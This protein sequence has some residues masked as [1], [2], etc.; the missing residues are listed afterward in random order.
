[1]SVEA[2]EI[3][4]PA[5]RWAPPFESTYGPAVA[6]LAAMAGLV[7]DPEQRLA[8]D[9]MFAEDADGKWSSFEFAIVCARQNMKTAVLQAAVLGDLFLLED[10]LVIWTA[11]LFDTA[12]EAFRDIDNL[13]SASHEMSRR[14]LKVN[15]AN[16]DEGFE[17]KTGARLKFKARSKTA[18]RGL[19]GDKV[20][21]DEAFA[22]SAGEMGALLPTM[23][24]RPNPQLRYA[25]SAG[26]ESSQFLRG[27]RDR[28]R[29]GGDPSLAYLEWC[30]PEGSCADERCVH[31]L[32]TPGCALDDPEMWRWANPAMDRRISRE[33]IAS[34]RRALATEP[35]EFARERLGW[36][37]DPG[38]AEM[39]YPVR[40]W[41]A[42]VDSES[43]PTYAAPVFAI[44]TNPIRTKSAIAVC[45]ANTDGVQ[46]VQLVDFESG[47]AWVPARVK[48]LQ[49]KYDA[50][51]VMAADS[52]ASSLLPELEKLG[53]RVTTANGRELT[54]ACGSMFDALRDRSF[55]HLGQ[56]DLDDAV[57]MARK[58]E[59][60]GAWAL[61]RKGGDI[62]PLVAAVLARHYH[63]AQ[64][65]PQPTVAFL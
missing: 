35:E 37:S 4:H 28:G 51:V 39:P 62:A 42:L 41:A 2:P 1:M 38:L 24:A 36:W 55:R 16:G 52:A 34:E 23:S 40:D 17:F 45:C 53:V 27:I 14:V 63:A 46:H 13:I 12:Q 31:A 44:D 21:L 56:S 15:R 26:L 47:T 6:D 7:L 32:G 8:L 60:E 54:Q 49:D 64:G 5:H 20:I 59:F 9:L 43:Q 22:L 65:D 10:R 29:R 25:S 11:H 30:A 57:A 3:V 18:G 48:E 33:H 50:E 58:R 19:T 61:A